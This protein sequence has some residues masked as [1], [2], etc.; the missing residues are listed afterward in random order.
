MHSPVPLGD[1]ILFGD[2]PELRI[3]S[4]EGKNSPDSFKQWFQE[5]HDFK[6]MTTANALKLKQ[7]KLKKNPQ[8]PAPKLNTT[9]AAVVNKKRTAYEAGIELLE[10]DVRRIKTNDGET[11]IKTVVA[12]PKIN[13]IELNKQRIKK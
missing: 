8:V 11:V 13:F 5:P 12:K 7:A 3:E 1:M 10:A 4:S 2:D 6:L 9:V